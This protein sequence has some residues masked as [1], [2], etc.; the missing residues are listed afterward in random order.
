MRLGQFFLVLAWIGMAAYGAA[1]PPIEAAIRARQYFESGVTLER[2]GQYQQAIDALTQAINSHALKGEDAARAAFDRGV[3][4]DALGDTRHAIADYTGALRLDPNLAAALSNRG[5]AFRR[6]GKLEEAKR[7]Y[8]SALRCPGADRQYPYYGLGLIA[9]KFGDAET[10]RDYFQKALAVDPSFALAAQSLGTLH[11]ISPPVVPAAIHL[12]AAPPSPA[13]LH[14][15]IAATQPAAARP[16]PALRRAISDTAEAGSAQ[17]QLG[18]FREERQASEAW[19]RISHAA[20]EALNGLRPII[21]AA[22]LPGRG[23]YWR[24]RLELADAKAAKQLCAAL[25]TQ[26]QA[27]LLV[28]K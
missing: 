8:F 5:N 25:S 20:G 1:L 7:D 10:A 13:R 15:V 24:V 4:Y 9:Q 21:V 6:M 19:N 27:C 12:A 11:K 28:R 23:R 16:N 18:A 14:Q 3:A 26:R 2:L 17:V 22:D